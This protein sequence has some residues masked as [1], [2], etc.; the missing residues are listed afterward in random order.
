MH[1]RKHPKNHRFVYQLFASKLPPL[2]PLPSSSATANSASVPVPG[3]ALA[4]AL[5]QLAVPEDR[6]AGGRV[7]VELDL[8]LELELS[9]WQNHAVA[10]PKRAPQASLS[11]ALQRLSLSQGELLR[12]LQREAPRPGEVSGPES[13]SRGGNA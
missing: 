12:E 5:R 8:A 13:A 3:D 1:H 10:L 9:A 7:T 2:L 4:T 11:E 6:V